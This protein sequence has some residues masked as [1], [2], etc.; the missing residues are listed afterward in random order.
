MQAS[1]SYYASAFPSNERTCFFFFKGRDE[2]A[3]S[4][5]ITDSPDGTS[6]TNKNKSLPKARGVNERM[7]ENISY[8]TTQNSSPYPHPL[9]III[10][11]HAHT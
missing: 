2:G 6:E 8:P 1:S 9:F 10:K 3:A 7:K 5:E 11:T 4:A